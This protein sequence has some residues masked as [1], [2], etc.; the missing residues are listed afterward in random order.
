M[1]SIVYLKMNRLLPGMRPLFLAA[2]L[3]IALLGALVCGCSDEKTVIPE[4]DI[5]DQREKTFE[6][7]KIISRIDDP[8]GRND[9][10]AS[11]G[12]RTVVSQASKMRAKGFIGSFVREGSAEVSLG[13]HAVREILSFRGP[14]GS[15][16]APLWQALDLKKVNSEALHMIQRASP[17]ARRRI[18]KDLEIFLVF[19]AAYDGMSQQE[20]LEMIDAWKELYGSKLPPEPKEDGFYPLFWLRKNP[21][22]WDR[23]GQ[24]WWW[25]DRALRKDPRFQIDETGRVII[26]LTEPKRIFTS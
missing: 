1:Y 14:A 9:G 26:T 23:G 24:F 8:S 15:A 21:I 25:A 5:T 10:R 20:R 3:F 7:Q 22:F 2:P 4:D 13:R 19:K 6:E 18:I 11:G 17:E 12:G 16:E